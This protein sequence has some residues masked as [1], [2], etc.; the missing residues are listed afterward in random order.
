MYLLDCLVSDV[1]FLDFEQQFRYNEKLSDWDSAP[2]WQV[3]EPWFILNRLSHPAPGHP[4]YITQT[5]W[6]ISSLFKKPP[7]QTHT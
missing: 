1:I 6:T 2:H 7:T 3:V 5:R 4:V